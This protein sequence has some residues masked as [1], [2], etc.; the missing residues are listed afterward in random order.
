[1]RRYLRPILLALLVA[2]PLAARA[3]DAEPRYRDAAA[4]FHALKAG[5]AAEPAAW[6]DLAERFLAIHEAFPGSRR[7][8]DALFSGALA[9]GEA[10]ASGQADADALHAEA[11]FRRFV[12][13]YPA[14]RLADD[15]L[16]HLGLL[17]E[18]RHARE[19][20]L[21]FYRRV[22]EAYPAGDQAALARE[23][24]RRSAPP[25]APRSPQAEPEPPAPAASPLR[26]ELLALARASFPADGEATRRPA[27]GGV[28]SPVRGREQATEPGPGPVTGPSTGKRPRQGA[29]GAA[30]PGGVTRSAAASTGQR[31]AGTGA[32]LKR[33]QFWSALG[34]TRVIL[35]TDAP[36]AYRHDT[37]PPEPGRAAR[38]YLDLAG[39]EP[40][41]ELAAEQTVGDG[42]LES[43]RVHRNGRGTL[44]VVLELKSLE[45][46]TV[47]EFPLPY[48]KK[49]VVDL[50]PRPVPARSPV[51]PEEQG[52]AALSLKRALGLKVKTLVID[53]GHGGHD[54]G[55]TA[56]GLEEKD[57]ALKIA[58]HLRQV[59]RE[60]RPEIAVG[61]TR[62]A[63]VFVPLEQRPL[64]AR[65][66]GADLFVSIH[67]NASPAER[68]SGIESYFLNL[69]TDASALQVAARENASTEKQV[70]DLNGILMDLLRDTNIIESGK[71][72]QALQASLVAGLGGAESVRDLG[73][74]QAPFMVLV[75]AEMPS[76]LVEAGFI[77]NREEN[78]RM[79][80]DRYL[81][82]IA[83][84]IYEGLLRY[85]DQGPAPRSPALAWRPAG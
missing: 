61:M 38:L 77:T 20:A 17:A 53:A 69:T 74:K 29:T 39:A 2:L 72:A 81:R 66:Q 50:Y 67:L 34:F 84:G 80:D 57:V 31:A 37:L 82:R 23:Q 75:G 56:L 26:E 33:V 58:R 35:T 55:A 41:A 45:R 51:P 36:V 65:K 79:R 30:G 68:A 54:P 49:I 76:V 12:E 85:I 46:Y 43:V 8:A 4:R 44:R 64:L 15:A 5:G 3:Q 48:E 59:F 52:T 11:L 60:R 6:R 1:M 19:A 7:A 78:R 71:L 9:Y 28:R 16:M 25:A 13:A 27:P 73:V 83:E 32:V 47:K 21:V 18:R 10:H 70:S 42:V 63:D 22:L 14:S 62:E 24:V 40:D